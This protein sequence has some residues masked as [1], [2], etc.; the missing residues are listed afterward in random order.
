MNTD[1]LF[2]ILSAPL[3]YASGMLRERL[4]IRCYA[5]PDN[6]R[7]YAKLLGLTHTLRILGVLLFST[8]GFAN[9]TLR[10]HVVS[11]REGGW[12]N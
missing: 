5:Q 4:K 2:S 1:N 9:E 6:Y 10:V 8:R 7:T 12:I 3:R 11:R